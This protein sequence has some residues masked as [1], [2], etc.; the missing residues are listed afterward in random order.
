MILP[1]V[2]ILGLGMSIFS[3]WTNYTSPVREAGRI[4]RNT[5]KEYPHYAI[6]T[7][8]DIYERLDVIDAY[9]HDPIFDDRQ[10]NADIGEVTKADVKILFGEP[11]EIIDREDLKN[12][13]TQY[14]YTWDDITIYFNEYEHSI[15]EYIIEHA[16]ETVYKPDILDTL[17][18]D[19]V[20]NYQTQEQ[21]DNDFQINETP[22]RKIRQSGWHDWLLNRQDY[23]Q[24]NPEK[25]PSS[26]HLVLQYYEEKEKN[27]YYLERQYDA[28]SLKN[29][30][31]EEFEKIRESI[32]SIQDLFDQNSLETSDER[33]IVDDFSKHFGEINRIVYDFQRSTLDITWLV[34]DGELINE[35]T[36]K[37]LIT[38]D[39]TL[40]SL[41]DLQNLDVLDY[42]TDLY[43]R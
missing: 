33:V 12:V 4:F 20:R 15:D 22:S 35:I 37:V 40:S 41:N 9:Y 31:R 11:H 32:N 18:L 38:D 16:T 30:T 29:K 14:H 8:D 27:L 5:A 17:F 28:A 19:T 3:F 23:F 43:Y 24:E 6:E 7:T 39:I 21:E 25:E 13:D 2:A 1:I 42:Q 34:D 10:P 36:A 26:E